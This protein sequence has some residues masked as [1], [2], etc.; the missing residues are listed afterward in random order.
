M[1]ELTALSW[2]STKRLSTL[3]DSARTNFSNSE[4][5]WRSEGIQIGGVQS[6]R[7]VL[8]TWFDKY[9]ASPLPYQPTK[10]ETTYLTINKQR[11]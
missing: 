2:S 11:L 9:V 10:Q 6:A 7:G 1:G 5:R 4:E 8:G 3:L